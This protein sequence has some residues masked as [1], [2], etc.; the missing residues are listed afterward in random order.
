M[1]RSTVRIIAILIFVMA[2]LYALF[3][4]FIGT[5]DSEAKKVS[6]TVIQKKIDAGELKQLTI[7]QQEVVA[8]DSAGTELHAQVANEF[9]KADLM[10][11]A[12]AEANGKRKVEKVEDKFG[13]IS[14]TW[15]IFLFWVSPLLSLLLVGGALFYIGY[16][17]GKNK[18]PI[19]E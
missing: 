13:S 2:T 16:F 4:A 15:Q 12:T 14:F 9:Y 18:R 3:H 5:R 10:K 17:M 8:I 11:Q 7:E 6:L 19:N 1:M